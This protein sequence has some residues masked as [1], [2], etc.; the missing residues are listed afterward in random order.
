MQWESPYTGKTHDIGSDSYFL[1]G[2]NYIRPMSGKLIYNPY[3]N[4]FVDID[5]RNYEKYQLEELY[6]IAKKVSFNL[7][8]DC[9]RV[10]VVYPIGVTKKMDTMKF[11]S[12]LREHDNK[13]KIYD[14]DRTFYDKVSR[15]KIKLG[16]GPR[17]RSGNVALDVLSDHNVY[18][19]IKLI[20]QFFKYNKSSS[21]CTRLKTEYM[22]YML[23]LI[24]VDIEW[25]NNA[26][27]SILRREHIDAILDY[28]GGGYKYV[29]GCLKDPTA[30]DLDTQEYDD[31]NNPIEG[32]GEPICWG[33]FHD[34]AG[35]VHIRQQIKAIDE[36][37]TIHPKIRKTTVVYRRTTNLGKL[38]SKD[39]VRKPAAGS[40]SDDIEVG[41]VY[42]NKTYL[43]TSISPSENF[44]RFGGALF[45]L[46]LPRGFPY[47][48]VQ[49]L[50][51]GEAYDQESLADMPIPYQD[52]TL[53]E[54]DDYYNDYEKPLNGFYEYE[55]LLPRDTKIEVIEILDATS[56]TRPGLNNCDNGDLPSSACGVC[57]S[58]RNIYEK[59]YVC[60]VTLDQPSVPML[61][62][63]RTVEVRY[64]YLSYEVGHANVKKG[65]IVNVI[66]EV[67][68]DWC[69]VEV[70]FAQDDN[71]LN[72]TGIMP[73]AY[74]S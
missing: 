15:C 42:S 22:K 46:I 1:E 3:T 5:S 13:Y 9:T 4:N 48:N 28:K 20:Q 67:D 60:K 11:I 72:T 21:D 7:S 17:S 36:L 44:D 2:L 64:D 41:D 62:A 40:S 47:I 45:A 31:D 63:Q 26:I 53:K 58:E 61:P 18:K 25:K 39:I 49:A 29:N 35:E 55:L 37:F 66:S 6:S 30:K 70:V 57:N 56:W 73:C 69:Y 33:G 54:K 14:I 12:Y 43:S 23:K 71:R 74:L 10:Y 68:S 24:S 27:D 38:I 65:E 16:H 19:S 52:K 59:I 32:T 8:K 51:L 50:S 34:E